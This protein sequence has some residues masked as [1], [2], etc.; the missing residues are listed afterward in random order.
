[1]KIKKQFPKL[2]YPRITNSGIEKFKLKKAKKYLIYPEDCK[3]L[4]E[5]PEELIEVIS[6]GKRKLQARA[7]YKRGNCDWWKFTWPLHREHFHRTKIVSPYMA[8]R[9]T[10]AVDA[11]N[12]GMYL[13]DTTVI[14]LTSDEIPPMALCALLNSEIMDFRFHYLTKLKGGGVKEYFAKQIERLPVPFNAKNANDV[15]KLS[16]LGQERTNLT[17]ILDSTQIEKEKQSLLSKIQEIDG[18]IEKV[19]VKLFG[20]TESEYETI[21]KTKS[22]WS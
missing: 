18:K 6:A 20:L 14:Y 11:N 21:I 22:E 3:K 4:T 13:T 9:N 16:E 17:S 19:V 1:L 12:H 15:I 10:F 7:A 2:V 5:L 8:E